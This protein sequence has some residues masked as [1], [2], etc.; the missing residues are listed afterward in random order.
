MEDDFKITVSRDALMGTQEEQGGGGYDARIESISG[1]K[2]LYMDRTRKLHQ[3][4]F[5]CDVEELIEA[6]ILDLNDYNRK[7]LG[8][9]GMKILNEYF[10]EGKKSGALK[11]FLIYMYMY[12]DIYLKES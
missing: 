4:G 2:L 5:E 7:G 12:Q 8:D 9:N 6:M 1:R 10:N 11:E 3:K